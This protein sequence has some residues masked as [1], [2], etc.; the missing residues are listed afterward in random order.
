MCMGRGCVSGRGRKT[1]SIALPWGWCVCPHLAESAAKTCEFP[2]RRWYSAMDGASPW[3]GCSALQ[4]GWETFSVEF[5]IVPSACSTDTPRV[6][7]LESCPDLHQR[8][9][10]R[11]G[12]RQRRTR[13]G[14]RLVRP[15]LL[16]AQWTDPIKSLHCLHALRMDHRI[17][18]VRPRSHTSSWW[19]PGRF[20]KIGW[21][22]LHTGSV[23]FESNLTR[24]IVIQRSTDEDTPSANAFCKRTLTFPCNQP[25]ILGVCKVIANEPRSLRRRP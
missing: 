24:S 6:Y 22:E 25:A 10:H 16:D 15:R 4:A 23:G 17:I 21:L 1:W 20:I 11:A 14:G 12:H 3:P 13:V 2:R 7:A 5:A 8:W 9:R 18:C 19:I